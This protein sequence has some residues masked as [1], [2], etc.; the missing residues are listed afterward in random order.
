ME[1]YLASRSGT[2]TKTDTQLLETPQ[3][4]STVGRQEMNDRNTKT[5]AEAMRYT[6]GVNVD[7]YGVD[8]RG[9][10]SIKI[11]GFDSV[12]TGSFRDGLRM[13]GNFFG[14]Y[15]TEAYGIER[16]DMMRGPSGALYGQAEAGGVID[17][18]TKRPY[19]G[20][21]QEVRP[22]GGRWEFK[23]GAFDIGVGKYKVDWPMRD[24]TER[25]CASSWELEA[26]LPEKDRQIVLA[27]LR[28]PSGVVHALPSGPTAPICGT[29]SVRLSGPENATVI[30]RR[31]VAINP[32]CSPS[33][34]ST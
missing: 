10:D 27:V 18:T 28:T 21:Q 34:D 22:Q 11:R 15:T 4:I 12:T 20:M 26:V 25:V 13:D 29:N 17:R 24:R 33:G 1:G 8:P 7:I 6:A 14:L 32:R 19:A 9:F 30:G 16:V 5:V 31:C 23:E 2:G 3:S